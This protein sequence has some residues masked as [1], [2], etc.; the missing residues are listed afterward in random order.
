MRNSHLYTSRA[1]NHSGAFRSAVIGRMLPLWKRIS[2]SYHTTTEFS[3]MT[4]CSFIMLWCHSCCSVHF[5]CCHLRCSALCASLY[6]CNI[7]LYFP[8]GCP[9]IYIACWCLLEALLCCLGVMLCSSL[10][11]SANLD[12]LLRM[13]LSWSLMFM[14]NS[15]G[16][17]YY[18]CKEIKQACKA[19]VFVLNPCWESP[20][21]LLP[22]RFFITLN[23]LSI[24]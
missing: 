3:G 9:I 6:I 11:S 2:Q 17:S 15:S 1:T 5:L 19:A 23:Y 12:I 10:V 22:S 4:L 24:N 21:G 8:L 20:V 7:K 18:L 13:L 16:P 14:R